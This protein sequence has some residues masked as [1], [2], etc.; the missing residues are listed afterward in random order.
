MQIL[1]ILLIT[2][3][4]MQ[5]M[6]TMGLQLHFSEIL[7]ATTRNPNR[8]VRIFIA[9][10]LVVPLVTM[11][12]CQLLTND[13][14]IS[15][16]FLILS[17]APAAPYGPPFTSIARGDLALATGFMAILAST[18][19][20]ISP[21]ILHFTLPL[22]SNGELT[23]KFDPIKMIGSLI[24]IQLLPLFIGLW[25]VQIRPVL[26][27]RFLKPSLVIS[28]LL[29]GSMILFVVVEYVGKLSTIDF[30]LVGLIF[31]IVMTSLAIGWFFGG[32]NRH[33]RTATSITTGLRNMSLGMGFAVASFPGTKTVT[34]T[35]AYTFIGGFFLLLY[36]IFMRR[37]NRPTNN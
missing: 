4:I 23:L 18:S 19:V 2:L 17:V 21:F 1:L 9:N 25:M 33:V 7:N 31:L 36:T 30:N 22:I 12:I 24:I 32:R 16:A 15:A 27:Q 28:K 34:T 11:G 3:T 5:M 35:L 8:T 13:P 26:A 6:F 37:I 10:Y 29:N 14:Y 20:I